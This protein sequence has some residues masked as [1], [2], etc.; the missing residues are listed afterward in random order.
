MQ[1]VT[2]EM[3]QEQG[4]SQKKACIKTS[5]PYAHVGAPGFY[6]RQACSETLRCSGRAGSDNDKIQA[7]LP[8]GRCT[9]ISFSHTRPNLPRFRLKTCPKKKRKRLW[10]VGCPTRVIRAVH[11]G[12]AVWNEIQGH[13]RGGRCPWIS[14]LAGL[15][16][17]R[18]G[19]S[20]QDG[21]E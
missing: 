19:R 13:R 6:S 9:W 20:G 11:S 16:R 15:A 14:F 10:A 8:G 12:P 4:L 3:A 5:G 21:S 17:E 1:R 18:P 2:W 7:P